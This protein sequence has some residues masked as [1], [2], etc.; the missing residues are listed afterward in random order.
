MPPG[1]LAQ[2]A[3]AAPGTGVGPGQAGVDPALVQED[4]AARIDPGQLGAP[5]RPLL[6]DIGAVLLGR[7]ERLFFRTSTLL[8]GSVRVATRGQAA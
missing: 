2:R 5:R 1:H 7:P 3:P 6:E 8:H 4:Q